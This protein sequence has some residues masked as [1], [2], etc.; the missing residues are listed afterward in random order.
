MRAINLLLIFDKNSKN[1]YKYFV[2]DL[3]REMFRY[4]SLELNK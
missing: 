2:F 1:K 3:K 4:N